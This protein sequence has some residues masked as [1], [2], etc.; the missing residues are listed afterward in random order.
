MDLPGGRVTLG[1]TAKGVGMI[2]PSMATM[3]CFIATD[4]TVEPGFLQAA[5]GESVDASFNMIDVD[6][7][8]STNDTVLV[9]GARFVWKF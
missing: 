9:F 3:L 6:G 8:Q 4:A 2:H 7:D 5:L 1:G